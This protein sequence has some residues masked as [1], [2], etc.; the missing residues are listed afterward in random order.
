MQ[1]GASFRLTMR[2]GPHPN[3]V[4]ELTR[5]TLT[6]GRDITNDIMINDPEVSRHHARLTRTAAGYMIED[7][8]ST[9][10]TFIN[11]Q[12]ITTSYQLAN[13]DV[14]GLGETVTLVYETPLVGAGEAVS[15]TRASYS[16][17]APLP[18]PPPP[19]VS[20]YEEEEEEEEESLFERNRWV[21]IGCAGLVVI[22]CCA[23]VIGGIV[24]DSY[25]LWCDLPIIPS[26]PGVACP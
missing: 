26:L 22:L 14:V 16:R 2:R 9:N 6:I 8:R 5:D 23:I 7:L 25:N 24:V 20:V 15:T 17:E 18:P 12:R 13:G 3:Q 19:P 1:S 11:R 4:Y 21:V 10:G